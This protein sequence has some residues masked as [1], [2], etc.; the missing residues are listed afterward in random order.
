MKPNSDDS[1][2]LGHGDHWEALGL[3]GDALVTFMQT[4]FQ[5]AQPISHYAAPWPGGQFVQLTHWEWSCASLRF[6]VITGLSTAENSPTCLSA[7]PMVTH[8]ED[9]LVQVNQLHGHYGPYEGMVEG[10]AASGHMLQWFAPR[11]GQEVDLWRRPGLVRVSLGAL[12]LRMRLFPTAPIVIHEGPVVELSK[13]K[14]RREGRHA[15]ADD[16]NFSITFTM[17]NLRTIYA[18]THDHHEFVGKL[19]DVRPVTPLP[20]CWGWR[21]K[22]VCLPDDLPTGHVLSMLVFPP[23]LQDGYRPKIGDLVCGTAWLQ[24]HYRSPASDQERRLWDSLNG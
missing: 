19:I 3:K 8:R 5:S 1:T 11:F 4:I 23:A 12:A 22:M 16:P 13:Q 15:E 6:E 21:V 14:L 7:F 24:G 20:Q 18:H 9:W 10:E 17:Q 2:L